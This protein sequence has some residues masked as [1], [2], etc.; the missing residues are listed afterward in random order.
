MAPEAI[1]NPRADLVRFLDGCDLDNK[2]DL[3]TKIGVRKWLSI[4][5]SKGDLRLVFSF[6]GGG[7]F[8]QLSL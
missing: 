4:G 8:L 2:R 1:K 7:I 5:S 6:L 3:E